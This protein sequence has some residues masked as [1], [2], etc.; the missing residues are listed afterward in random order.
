MQI[1]W[2]FTKRRYGS[3]YLSVSV[4]NEFYAETAPNEQEAIDTVNAELRRMTP[5]AVRRVE[6]RFG[7]QLDFT[8]P[9]VTSI[10]D[11][12]PGQMLIPMK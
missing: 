7:V 4:D 3:V 12:P 9:T 6:E 5:N 2:S 1:D 8:C 11:E 10:T